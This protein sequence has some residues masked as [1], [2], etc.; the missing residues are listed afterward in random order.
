MMASSSY[1]PGNDEEGH[2]SMCAAARRLFEE[3]ADG[4]LIVLSYETLL[5]TGSILD[6]PR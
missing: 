3:E 2:D 6:Q 1:L 4:D 5:F